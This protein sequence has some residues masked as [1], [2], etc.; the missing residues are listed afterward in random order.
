MSLQ[1]IGQLSYETEGFHPLSLKLHAKYTYDQ[2]LGIVKYETENNTV[3]TTID[4]IKT[5]EIGIS[6]RFSPNERHLRIKGKRIVFHSPDVDFRLNHRMG[7]KGIFGS[8][9]NYHITDAGIF[10][11]FGL[12]LNTGSFGVKLSGGKVWNSVPFPLL[13]IPSGNQSYVFGA[14]S[15]N[16]M[17]YYEFI[18]DRFISGNADLQLNWSPVKLL[19]KKSQMKM[20]GGIKAIYGPLSDKNNPQL[21]PELF[22]FNNGVE[23]LGNK[24]YA[25]VN[26]GLSGILKYLRIDYVRRLTYGNKGSVFVSTAYRF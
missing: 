26:I 24:P 10:K 7:V 20:H 8:D 5:S 17:R 12:P 16:L 18:T 23:S 15:Y 21:H 19:F 2:P 25:E 9:F 6:L 14:N 13:F 11:S 1:K 4:N 22:V 3:R